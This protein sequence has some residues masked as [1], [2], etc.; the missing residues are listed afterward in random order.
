MTFNIDAMLQL[1]NDNSSD[2]SLL[3]RIELNALLTQAFFVS[4]VTEGADAFLIALDASASYE[5]ENFRWFCD[6]YDRFVYI[7]RVIVA[8]SCRGRGL[9]SRLYAELAEKAKSKGW[10]YLACEINEDPPNVKSE[11]FHTRLGFS[12]IGGAT[13]RTGKVVRYSVRE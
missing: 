10:P 6:R 8:A 2:T 5:N 13:L 7:D 1:N 11:V 12:P 3:T 9:A 4:A